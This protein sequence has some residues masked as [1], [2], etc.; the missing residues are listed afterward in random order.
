MAHP[1]HLLLTL[2]ISRE[3]ISGC[4]KTNDNKL[5]FIGLQTKHNKRIAHDSE[6]MRLLN[7]RGPRDVMRIIKIRREQMS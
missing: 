2:S 4:N 1:H 7:G 3:K 5:E 6:Y